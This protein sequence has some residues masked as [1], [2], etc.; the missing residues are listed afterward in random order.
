MS[1]YK[2]VVISAKS[3]IT[4]KVRSLFL[5][6]NYYNCLAEWRINRRTKKQWVYITSECAPEPSWPTGF[7]KSKIYQPNPEKLQSI[8]SKIQ[9]SFLDFK[10][11]CWKTSKNAQILLPFCEQKNTCLERVSSW[12]RI[13]CQSHI[14]KFFVVILAYIWN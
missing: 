6:L 9:A 4:C 5:F 10:G 7:E 3:L 13:Y 12:K 1:Y 8:G 2:S 11:K 14:S